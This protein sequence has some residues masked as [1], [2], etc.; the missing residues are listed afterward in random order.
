MPWA[1]GSVRGEILRN[2]NPLDGCK[3]KLE[4]WSV[5]VLLKDDSCFED[6][7]MRQTFSTSSISVRRWH[8]S[9]IGMDEP[10]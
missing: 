10:I 3:S 5:V 2:N 7:S 4:H 8:E 1:H 6:T 9:A